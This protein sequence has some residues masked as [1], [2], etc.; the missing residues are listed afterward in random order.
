MTLW[1]RLDNIDKAIFTFIHAKAAVPWLDWLMLAIRNG[2]TW[3]PL[4]VFLLYWILRY[5]LKYSWQFILLSVV[6]F[7]TTNHLAVE[8]IKPHFQRLRP[9][10]DAVLQPILRNILDCGGRYSL[11]SAHAANHFGLAAF[12]FLS[13]ALINGKR[14]YW[15]W[16]WAFL[17]GYAQVYVGKHYPFD[18]VLGAVIGIV[19][20]V[21]CYLLFKVLTR[22]RN[23][24]PILN[25]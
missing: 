15:F 24:L 4:Y 8:I 7:A 5:H 23:R 6:C 19:T 17:V 3:I 20:G 18:I 12:W 9:C 10:H 14:L 16:L 25:H 11:P 1:E 13:V 2:Y 21:I 22:E